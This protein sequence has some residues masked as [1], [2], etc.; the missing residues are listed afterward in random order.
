MKKPTLNKDGTLRKRRTT[1]KSPNNPLVN[2]SLEQISDL[3]P[4]LEC[5]IPVSEEWVKGR[6]YARYLNN[7]CV[8]QDFS[9]TQSLED[10]IEYA[11]TDFNNE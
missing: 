6:L 9:E 5:E 4:E 8:T 3:L 11:L 2:L 1:K 7:K 10:T